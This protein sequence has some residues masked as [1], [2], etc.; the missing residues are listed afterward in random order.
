VL[1][2]A[3]SALR[4]W[5]AQ[6]RSQRSRNRSSLNELDSY[7]AT[8]RGH[9]ASYDR[10]RDET[11]NWVAKVD[12]DGATFTEA[13][14]VL[15]DMAESRQ[16]IKDAIAAIDAPPAVAA[17]QNRLV[18]VLGNAVQAMHD[19]TSGISDYQFNQD[20]YGFDY[21]QSPGWQE[22]ERSSAQISSDYAAARAGWEQ[23]VEQRRRS[24]RNR[25]LPPMPAV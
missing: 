20:D 5:Q 23:R 14:Q 15:G 10:L 7:V 4:Q 13:Y 1:A 3:D 19:A 17:A 8:V 11:S 21:K 16:N 18:L 2:H 25:D 24:T 9:L 12:R 22:F 6:T